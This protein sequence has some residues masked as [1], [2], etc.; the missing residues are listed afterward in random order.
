[1]ESSDQMTN[2]E[3]VTYVLPALHAALMGVHG[4]TGNGQ[5]CL[6]ALE[7]LTDH[8]ESSASVDCSR[9]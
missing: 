6:K 7:H 8:V 9:Q 4:V 3:F 2:H 5:F 1:M